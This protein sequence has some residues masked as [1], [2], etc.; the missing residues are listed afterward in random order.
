MDLQL[1]ALQAAGCEIIYEDHGQSGHDFNREG[2]L[3]ALRNIK[4]GSTLVVWR[5]DRL[6]RSLQGL[7][8]V[9][10]ELYVNDVHFRSLM[11]NIDTASSGGRLVFHMMGALAEFE[12]NL[13]KERT[14]AGLD[15]A[16][17]RG[18]RLGRPSAINEHQ[19]RQALHALHNQKR[20]MECIAID[21]G[22]SVR[23]LRRHLQKF[24]HDEIPRNVQ[25]P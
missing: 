13:I 23:T 9:I 16:R 1:R 6:G 12:R 19:V 14:Q 8:E 5:L 17:V 10:N 7:I 2:L 25:R 20:R 21:L 18:R 24:S 15:E 22:I 4:P 11:E 3:D